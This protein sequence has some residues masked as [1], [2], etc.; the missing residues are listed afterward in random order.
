MVI[1]QLLR[2]RLT[3]NMLWLWTLV[4]P[5]NRMVNVM[6]SISAIRKAGAPVPVQRDKN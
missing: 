6:L 2:D 3:P 1:A 4:W 5:M